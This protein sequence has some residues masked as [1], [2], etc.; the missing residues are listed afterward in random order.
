ME[1]IITIDGIERIYRGDYHELHNVD[2]NERV[3]DQIDSVNDNN[4]PN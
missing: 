1:I 4:V 3:R 2:W